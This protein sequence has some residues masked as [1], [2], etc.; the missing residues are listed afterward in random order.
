[1]E[2]DACWSGSEEYRYRNP[3]PSSKTSEGYS[4][5]PK[6][7]SP[8]PAASPFPPHNHPRT[9]TSSYRPYTLPH[10]NPKPQHHNHE[11]QPP[12]LPR[13][14]PPRNPRH[15]IRINTLPYY[16]DILGRLYTPLSPTGDFTHHWPP[17]FF[18]SFLSSLSDSSTASGS[19]SRGCITL[20]H[21]LAGVL[22]TIPLRLLR[23]ADVRRI[24]R[25]CFLLQRRRLVFGSDQEE[26]GSMR[27]F[28]RRHWGLGDGGDGGDSWDYE[29]EVCRE[30]GFADTDPIWEEL[31]MRGELDGGLHSGRG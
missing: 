12:Y 21:H 25:L 11:H 15:P 6:S 5:N 24:G 20:L 8:V 26:G 1:M 29:C 14:Y 19:G 10:H 22:G 17:G 30:D 4:H 2:Y 13:S 27:E 31:G 18:I 23:A 3:Q 7:P 9:S 28:E 16:L